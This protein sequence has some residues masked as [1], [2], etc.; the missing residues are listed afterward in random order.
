M[1]FAI[2]DEV[3]EFDVGAIVK[4]IALPKLELSVQVPL[5]GSLEYEPTVVEAMLHDPDWAV[6]ANTMLV[7]PVTV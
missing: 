4:V 7:P 2:L 3:V 5:V 6:V 1:S